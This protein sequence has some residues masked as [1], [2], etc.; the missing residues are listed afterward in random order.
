MT[1][2]VLAISGLVLPK[3]AMYLGFIIAL[4][5]LI[6]TISYVKGGPDARYVGVAVGSFPV[7][8]LALGAVIELIRL[9]ATLPLTESL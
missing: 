1:V 5:R 8:G 9:S 3:G 2:L 7:L 4:G 6:Y